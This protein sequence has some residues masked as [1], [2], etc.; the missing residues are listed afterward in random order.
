MDKN[1]PFPGGTGERAGEP[2]N[3]PPA[4]G[5]ALRLQVYLAHAGAAS[6]RGAEKLITQGR[7][8]V[9]G[10]TVSVL[11]TKVE[12]GDDVRLDGIPVKI[13]KRLHYIVLHKPPL[14]IC[15]AADPQGRALAGD[16]LPP[17]IRERLYT[18]GRLDYRSSGLI[19]FTNDGNFAARAG[20]PSAG[21]EKEY[22]VEASGPIP[23]M[24]LEA[25]SL[26]IS[27][28][29]VF[30]KAEAV[31]RLGK[32]ALRVVLIEGKNRE[33]RRVFSHFHLHPEKLLRT[34]IGPVLLGELGE[35]KSRPLT[36]TEFHG[37]G[38]RLGYSH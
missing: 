21:I 14:Y 24:V 27:I 15:S 35:G 5:N 33:I 13:E 30:Y 37:L 34:R 10:R 2:E 29:G 25:F 36:G 4:G 16:L 9:N 18:V 23:D 12:A 17:A 26:G 6:R 3:A 20:H 1:N 7:V 19:L 28:E 32:K 38:E 22:L 31:K 11:G 8:T